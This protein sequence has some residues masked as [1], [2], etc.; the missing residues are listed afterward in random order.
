MWK[1]RKNELESLIKEGLSYEEIGR[2]YKCSGSNIK[3]VAIRL[4]IELSP[5]RKINA[6]EKFNRGTAKKGVCE[7][8]GREYIL[9]KG[10]GGHYCSHECYVDAQR[11]KSVEEWKNGTA[12]GHDKRYKI[13]PLIR[14]YF[15]KRAEYKCERCEFSGVNPYTGKSIL[16]LH[17]KDGNAAN[18]SEEN[19]E[20]LCPNCHAMTENFG[21]RNKSSV[22]KYKKKEYREN[23]DKIKGPISLT[24]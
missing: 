16:Q 2:R 15:L 22:K 20:V 3:K 19:I 1:D 7:H 8:C 10:H 23:E 24:E 9:Y 18:V 12:T 6:K 5:R 11:K 17:H 4:G 21:S 13:K 14:E